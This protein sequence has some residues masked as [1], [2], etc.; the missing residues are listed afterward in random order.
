MNS[1][2]IM[3]NLCKDTA[4]EYSTSGTAYLRNSIAVRRDKDTSDFFS[5]TAFGK[6][7]E[8]IEKYFSKGSK[9]AITGHLQS[10]Q[11]EKDGKKIPTVTIIVDKA[12]F[13][14]SKASQGRESGNAENTD[15]FLNVPDGLVEELP[16]S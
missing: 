7:A 10:G 3:G 16:F 6:G 11:Y 15:G 5:I 13:C 1:V 2:N 8:F 14:E 9:I 4:L 12:D